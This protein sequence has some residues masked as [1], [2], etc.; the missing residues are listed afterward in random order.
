MAALTSLKQRIVVAFVVFALALC[1]LFGLGTTI[2]IEILEARLIDDR[3]ESVAEW[4]APRHAGGLPVEMPEGLG[5][6]HGRAVP[7]SLRGLP[8]GVHTWSVDGIGVH[9][10]AGRNARGEYVVVDHA[11]DYERIESVIYAMIGFLFL[12]FLLFSVMLGR[13]VARRVVG[14][15]SALATAVSDHSGKSATPF[16]D[17]PDEMGVLA[18]AFDART[19]A[20]QRYLERERFFTGDVSHE[21]RTPLTVIRGAAE[22]LTLN[23]GDPSL[24]APADRI[25]SAAIEASNCVTVLLLLARAPDAL[26]TP[27]SSLREVL[28]D[29][30]ER[31]R[32]LVQTK[33]VSLRLIADTDLFI[34]ARPELLTAAIGNLIRNACAYT[35]QGAV[36][37]TLRGRT[38]CVEDTGPGIPEQIRNRLND[39]SLAHGA[40]R[41]A[42]GSGL[43]LALAQRI[44]EHLGA[45]L[46]IRPAA[47]R[48]SIVSIQ[49]PPSKQFP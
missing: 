8:P 4:A 18:R 49:F 41:R 27:E 33:P 14:P 13:F 31:C 16:V 38:V 34:A 3:L 20:L 9:V 39:E 21:L 24:R 23:A 29:E 6:Y 12:G 36:T 37:V 19:R 48:G 44:C 15:I 47:E 10:L 26:D 46:H 30:M 43:G 45:R 32:P 1:A 7:S 17:S 25:L 11:S 35:E 28:K 22:V 42:E 5:F 2:A 40:S